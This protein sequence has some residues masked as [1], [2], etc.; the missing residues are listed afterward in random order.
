MGGGNR[1]QVKPHDIANIESG[2]PKAQQDQGRELLTS[3]MDASE[4]EE[5]CA[6]VARFDG[7]LSGTVC[8]GGNI[9]HVFTVNTNSSLRL[10]KMG[11]ISRVKLEC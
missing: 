4:N 2:V 8:G 6:G 5:C 7:R 10:D 11:R 3:I 1:H 9:Y